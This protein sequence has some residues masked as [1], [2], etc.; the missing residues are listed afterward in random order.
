MRSEAPA[1]MS[2]ITTELVVQSNEII[3]SNFVVK[4]GDCTLADP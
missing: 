4:I 2:I 1:S 3:T